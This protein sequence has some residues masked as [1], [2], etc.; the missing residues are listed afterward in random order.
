MILRQVQF[1][2]V[3]FSGCLLFIPHL[4]EVNSILFNTVT[5]ASGL[6]LFQSNLVVLGSGSLLLFFFTIK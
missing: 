4:G 5:P 3:Q 6:S 1:S 2:S